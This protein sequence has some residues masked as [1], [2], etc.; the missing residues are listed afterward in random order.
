MF[1]CGCLLF[2]M[3]VG[4]WGLKNRREKR[5]FFL[6]TLRQEYSCRM[7]K[8]LLLVRSFSKDFIC[9]DFVNFYIVA[10]ICSISVTCFY[11][12]AC[13]KLQ[14]QMCLEASLRI[15]KSF[16]YLEI[17]ATL[18]D[19]TVGFNHVKSCQVIVGVSNSTVVINTLS[20]S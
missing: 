11:N 6:K 9:F 18:A 13:V 3:M 16:C 15:S 4:L 2:R 8:C 14:K 12:I 1:A 5:V 17:L 19:Y 10:K 7:W 20:L